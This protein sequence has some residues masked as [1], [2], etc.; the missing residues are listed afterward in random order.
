[1]TSG[2]EI[3][4]PEI[5][6]GA[7]PQFSG[8][9]A[10]MQLTSKRATWLVLTAERI[11][12]RTA[13]D[14]GMVNSSVP[15]SNSRRPHSVSPPKSLNSK[16]VISAAFLKDATDPHWNEDPGLA[17]YR[18]VLSKYV[19]DAN[20]SDALFATGYTA[21]QAVELVLR[22]CGNNLT[23]D[24]VMKQA[25]NFKHVSFDLFLSGIEV[26]TS[27]SD[28]TAVKDMNLMRFDEDSWRLFGGLVRAP[29][30]E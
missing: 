27:S 24:N 9:G 26:N 22:R 13:Q 11:D 21:A 5:S 10:Q 19:P 16:G 7:Y 8:P 14:W 6:F 3:G 12:G 18:D 4:M 28:F 20:R 23:R 2:F 1:L 17:R 30:S 15:A 29:A 25:A